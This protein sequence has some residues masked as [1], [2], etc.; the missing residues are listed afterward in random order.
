M[1]TDEEVEQS[2][3]GVREQHATFTPVEGR[4]LADG[5]FAQVS[6]DGR[7]TEKDGDRQAGPHG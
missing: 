3:D 1:V 5:D 6:L 4:P 7:P 2:L